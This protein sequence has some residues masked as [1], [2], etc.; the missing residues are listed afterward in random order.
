M[1]TRLLSH[2]KYYTLTDSRKIFDHR[3]TIIKIVRS[4]GFQVPKRVMGELM[5]EF[6]GWLLG[7]LVAGEHVGQFI[8]WLLEDSSGEEI[9]EEDLISYDTDGI[10]TLGIFSI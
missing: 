8:G 10:F 6:D 2:I 9:G 4:A 3:H 7:E 1:K 5:Q